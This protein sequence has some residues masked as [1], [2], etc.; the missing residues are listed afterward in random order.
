MSERVEM[1]GGRIVLYQGDALQVLP[2]LASGSVD[3]VVSD[4]PYGGD[5][6][7][8]SKRFTGSN[9]G[10]GR[11]NWP[12]VDGDSEPFDPTPWLGFP[13]VVLWGSNHFAQRL[14][15]GTTLVWIKKAD[16]LFGTFLSDAEVAWMKGGHGIY[17]HREQF[18]PPRRMLEG[19]GKVLHPMQK[20]R[21][22]MEWCLDMAKVPP[23]GLVLDP[24]MGSGTLGVACARTGRR[25]VG[26]EIDPHYFSV[27]YQRLEKATSDGPLFA[28]R[29][30]PLEAP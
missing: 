1:D 16:H 23:D 21:R 26:V 4:P 6:D 17:C 2:L 11:N 5:F 20:P 28:Q 15:V 10:E 7:L 24:Y 25:Y 19:G 9:R 29:S 12:A 18:P 8:D 14:S 27:A 13:R 3:A 22:L 30:L